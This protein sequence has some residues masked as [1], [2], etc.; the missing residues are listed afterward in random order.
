MYLS[1]VALD[2]QVGLIAD[3]SFHRSQ[4]ILCLAKTT[5]YRKF[6]FA[7]MINASD[8]DV[9]AL[10]LPCSSILSQPEFAM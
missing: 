9:P 10:T 2:G 1:V 6:N 5:G 4:M 8:I 3:L 7:R